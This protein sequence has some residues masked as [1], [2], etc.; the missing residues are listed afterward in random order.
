[1]KKNRSAFARL[2]GLM[3][4]GCILLTL[5][6]MASGSAGTSSDP[7]VTLSYLTEK[8]LPQV[9][10]KVDEK[11]A[12][13]ERELSEKLSEQVKRESADFARTY[14]AS[15]SVGSSGTS[16]DFAVVTLSRGQILY[17]EIGCEVMLRVGSASCV[18]SSAPGLIDETAGTTIAGGAALQKN[19]L[20]MATVTER[21]VKATADSTKLLVRGSYTI[22]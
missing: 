17:G 18:A 20:Y 21:G 3:L 8:F 12:A 15:S 16:V 1:M 22:G 6:A 5:T 13:Q 4:V 9:L 2:V 14:G 19:H 7:L 11:A 10:D